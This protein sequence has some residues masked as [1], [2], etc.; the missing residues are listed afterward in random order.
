M[1]AWC[2]YVYNLLRGVSLYVMFYLVILL[3]K[4][5]YLPDVSLCL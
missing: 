3:H 5:A 2:V 4:K 1:F